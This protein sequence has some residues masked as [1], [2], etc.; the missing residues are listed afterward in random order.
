MAPL[1]SRSGHSRRRWANDAARL[2]PPNPLNA[3]QDRGS[4]DADN[5]GRRFRFGKNNGNNDGNDDGDGEGRSGGIVGGGGRGRGRFGDNGRG[6]DDG[7]GNENGADDANGDSD[8]GGNRNS[9]SKGGSEKDG[10]GDDSDTRREDGGSGRGNRRIGD[11]FGF[12]FGFGRGKNDGDGSGNTNAAPDNSVNSTE[13]SPPPPPTSAPSTSTSPQTT[14]STETTPPS[15][16]VPAQTTA[17][18]TSTSSNPGVIL[19]Q[20]AVTA[21]ATSEVNEN[22]TVTAFIP[23]ITPSAVADSTNLSGAGEEEVESPNASSSVE[24]SVSGGATT[25]KRPFFTPGGGRGFNNRN[26]TSN[27]VGPPQVGM[28]RTAERVLISVGSIGGFILVCFIVWMVW[29]TMRKSRKDG[30]IHGSGTFPR[31]VP[32]KIPFFRRRAWQSLGESTTTQSRPPSYPEKASISVIPPGEGVFGSEK[33]QQ[34]EPAAQPW[35]LNTPNVQLPLNNAYQ[36]P[37]LDPESMYST[38]NP[39]KINTALT[40]SPVY[41]HQ[42]QGSFS[43][44]NAAHFG[45]LWTGHSNNPDDILQNSVSPVSYY[46]SQSIPTQQ[47]TAPYPIYR[48]PSRTLTDVS[49]L[50]SGFG[51]GDFIMAT[52]DS[53]NKNND[54][55]NIIITPPQ[56]TAAAPHP[57]TAR[58]SW[59]SQPQSQQQQHNL[60]QEPRPEPGQRRRRRRSSNRTLQ[61][62]RSSTVYTQASEDQPARFRSVASWVNQQTG[63]IQR[64]QQR[65]RPPS[66]PLSPSQG[67]NATSSSTDKAVVLL[68]GQGQGQG[69]GQVPGNP[70]IPGIPNLPPEEP[71]FGMMMDDEERPRKVESV[72]G[73]IVLR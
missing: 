27:R 57:Y 19:L 72:V 56:P 55:N 6:N 26:G 7:D 52:I 33:V 70:G 73:K 37:A 32:S 28:D 40:D 16:T 12:G 62:Q 65:H 69:Q 47:F 66:S 4:E 31:D 64:A 58:F 23:L 11:G 35:P 2:P 9:D 36:L 42:A 68:Q 49:S 67:D 48:Q 46:N 30:D 44:T 53:D 34:P 41:S 18:I 24:P 45:T 29:R 63:R 61:L 20:P 22:P 5:G 10:N 38:G 1:S 39:L 3:R 59:M 71:S 51:D 21:S 54:N 8:G 50:S 25:T 14:A 60:E 13:T 15:T 43:S 17:E